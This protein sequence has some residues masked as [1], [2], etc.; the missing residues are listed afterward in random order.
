MC[1]I[2]LYLWGTSGKLWTFFLLP[3]W[4]CRVQLKLGW[5]GGEEVSSLNIRWKKF[6]CSLKE[7]FKVIIKLSI[8]SEIWLMKKKADA[9]FWRTRQFFIFVEPFQRFTVILVAIAEAPLTFENGKLPMVFLS[10][11]LCL[12]AVK[13]RCIFSWDSERIRFKSTFLSRS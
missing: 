13:S 11:F 4:S 1:F 6:I 5:R 2:I 8:A 9:C 3:V 10:D 7:K 12:T